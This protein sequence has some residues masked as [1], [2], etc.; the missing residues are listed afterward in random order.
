ML[1]ELWKNKTQNTNKD[2]PREDKGA[3]LA[4]QIV[5]NPPA[6]QEIW[7]LFLDQEDPLEK[8]V[9]THSSTFAHFGDLH[10]QARAGGEKGPRCSGAGNL[11]VLLESD[12]CVEELLRAHQ[13]CQYRFALQDGTWD[14]S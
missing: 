11:G 3:S 6:M 5:R 13:G 12:W 7:I 9:A 10:I 8:G 4:A 2:A 14:F 1:T